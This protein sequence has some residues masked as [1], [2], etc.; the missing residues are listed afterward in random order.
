MSKVVNYKSLSPDLSVNRRHFL[1]SGALVGAGLVLGRP[2][3]WAGDKTSDRPATN[4][5]EAMK[6]P[7]GPL[8]LPGTAPGRVVEVADD[9]IFKDDHID[10][11]VLEQMFDKD[12]RV[13]F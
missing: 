8:S 5:D 6:A 12:I 11:A 10:K 2:D 13:D 9:H 7:K 4:I 1:K 3:A